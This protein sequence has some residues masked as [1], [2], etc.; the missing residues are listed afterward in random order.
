MTSAHKALISAITQLRDE[1][2]NSA[3]CE[4]AQALELEKCR[5]TPPDN[6][7]VCKDGSRALVGKHTLSDGT[8]CV[9]KYYYP[10]NLAKKINYSL[11]GSRCMRSWVAARA[12]MQLDIPTAEPMMIH[13]EKIA[14]GLM[15]KQSFL[16]CRLAPGIPLHEVTSEAS[17]NE[18]APQLKDAFSTMSANRISHGDL[19]ANNIIVDFD[20]RIRFIDLDG[21]A[22]LSPPETWADLWQR[23]RKRFLKNWPEHSFAR[24]LFSKTIPPA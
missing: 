24:Q 11:R 22:I 7:E 9:F 10:K 5:L 6:L 17:L 19:K 1:R 14:G 15:L 8:E 16:A 20:N 4:S 3:A 13:E 21:T 12:F 18:I 2:V 23:D